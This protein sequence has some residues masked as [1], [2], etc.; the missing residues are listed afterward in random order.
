[1]AILN[2]PTV[3]FEPVPLEVEVAGV[4]FTIPALPASGWLSILCADRPDGGDIFP[5]LL[6]D[7]QQSLVDD[8]IFEEKLDYSE[9]EQL[10]KEIITVV[11]GRQWW[12][13]LKILS[14]L[15]SEHATEILGE[16]NRYCDS[17]TIS[18]G[19]WVNSLYALLMRNRDEQDRFKLDSTLDAPPPGVEVEI[20]EAE[21]RASERAFFAMMNQG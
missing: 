8:L 15:Q 3:S 13:T 11:S 18:L 21:Q 19:M 4:V 5:G 6:D 17:A 16:I 1:M 2:D 20:S 9:I 12:W 10:V 7:D 14:T